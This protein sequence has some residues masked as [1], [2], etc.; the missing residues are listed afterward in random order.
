MWLQGFQEEEKAVVTIRATTVLWFGGGGFF[1]S[2]DDSGRRGD[3]RWS[4]QLADAIES[5]VAG[6]TKEAVVADLGSAL[7]QN[8]L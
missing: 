7:G 3:R 2:R 5:R 4:E 8:V 6:R 1:R